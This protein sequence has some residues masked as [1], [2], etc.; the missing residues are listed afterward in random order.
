MPATQK[1]TRERERR[2]GRREKKNKNPHL[3]VDT[4]TYR[5]KSAFTVIALCIPSFLFAPAATAG[6]GTPPERLKMTTND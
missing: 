3:S 6:L 4:K 2:G 1:S 5:L